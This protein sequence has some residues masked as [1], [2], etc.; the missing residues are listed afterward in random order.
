MSN[1][2]RQELTIELLDFLSNHDYIDLFEDVYDA[3]KSLKRKLSNN[4]TYIDELTEL[5][6]ILNDSINSSV[7]TGVIIIDSLSR[8]RLKSIL[9]LLKPILFLQE[10]RELKL[11]Q[12]LM[13]DIEKFTQHEWN[14]FHDCYFHVFGIHLKQEEMEELW[15]NLPDYLKEDSLEWGMNDTL[16]RDNF[17]EW[18]EE[19]L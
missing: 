17:I 13:K 18:L 9:D 19:N 6:I 14:H 3:Q 15:N 11:N 5:W 7:N 1:K 8:E 4:Q 2:H 10:S 16:W 12:L